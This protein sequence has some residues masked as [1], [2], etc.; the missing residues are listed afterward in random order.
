MKRLI[1]LGLSLAF[2]VG[3]FAIPGFTTTA[4]AFDNS[5]NQAQLTASASYRTVGWVQERDFDAPP[6]V[7][8]YYYSE[9]EPPVVHEYRYYEPEPPVYYYEPGFSIDVPFFSFHAG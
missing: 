3:S 7:R 8:H 5:R 4:H 1:I 9:P 2:L 6:A